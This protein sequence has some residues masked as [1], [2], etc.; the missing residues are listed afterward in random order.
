MGPESGDLDRPALS[1]LQLLP[2]LAVPGSVPGTHG[3]WGAA[4]MSIDFLGRRQ[5]P[6]VRASQGGAGASKGQDPSHHLS[7]NRQPGLAQ[8][9]PSS[10]QPV[11]PGTM[12]NT[13]ASNVVGAQRA[14][15]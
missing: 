14:I 9:A 4:E 1:P 2:Q 5:I 6:F 10:A 8:L 13:M 11:P 7:L 12:A 3:S 15:K